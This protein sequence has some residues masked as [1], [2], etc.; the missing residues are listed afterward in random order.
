LVALHAAVDALNEVS[1]M[2]RG[3]D[4]NTQRTPFSGGSGTLPSGALSSRAALVF[5]LAAA[6]V[7]LTVGLVLLSAVGWPLVPFVLVGG[8][9][10]LAY[11]EVFARRGLGELL[12]GLGLGLLPVAIERKRLD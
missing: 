5:G 4:L 7:G 8:V 6:G 9:S 11:S 3:I 1:D 12:A 2:R 10:V